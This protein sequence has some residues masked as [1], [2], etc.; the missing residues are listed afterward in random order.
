[1][2]AIMSSLCV[3]SI[4]IIE[5]DPLFL[6]LNWPLKFMHSLQVSFKTAITPLSSLSSLVEK[7]ARGDRRGYWKNTDKK[8]R[9]GLVGERKD[10]R[11]GEVAKQTY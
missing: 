6:V 7:R 2:H 10:G 8:N 4:L 9:K 3:S 1:M 11:I 5:P